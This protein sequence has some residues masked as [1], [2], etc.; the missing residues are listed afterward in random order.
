MSNIFTLLVV[1]L[2]QYNYIDPLTPFVSC[3]VSF[4]L[5]VRNQPHRRDDE[6]RI[7]GTV[8]ARRPVII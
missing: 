8:F 4:K 1:P 7:E 2:I 6:L 5:S 3:T